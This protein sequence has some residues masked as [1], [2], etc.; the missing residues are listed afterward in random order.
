MKLE[1]KCNRVRRE[2]KNETERSS[3]LPKNVRPVWSSL[4]SDGDSGQ[5]RASVEEVNR[6]VAGSLKKGI[7]E[8][9]DF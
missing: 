8:V 4:E 6:V 1:Y 3:G 7:M 5:R 2:S 9:R